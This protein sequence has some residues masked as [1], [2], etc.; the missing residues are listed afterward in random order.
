MDN[1]FG[2]GALVSLTPIITV[3]ILGIIYNHK[4]KTKPS[5]HYNE[6]IVEYAWE[7]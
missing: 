6:E 4:L 1:A 7:S 5:I 3:Q 2:I